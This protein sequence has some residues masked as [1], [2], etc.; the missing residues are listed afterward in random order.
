MVRKKK[1]KPFKPMEITR[2]KLNP[3]QAVL[4]CCDEGTKGEHDQP[5][6]DMQ[7]AGMCPDGSFGYDQLS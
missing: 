2:V 5:D 1:K 3:E 6:P 7:C 4:S